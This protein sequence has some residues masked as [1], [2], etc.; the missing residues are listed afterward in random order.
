MC[1][2]YMYIFNFILLVSKPANVSL[3]TLIP[4][5]PLNNYNIDNSHSVHPI[6]PTPNE[7]YPEIHIH[8]FRQIPIT[9]GGGSK[10]LLINF[11]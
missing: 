7:N 5:R 4:I 2:T 11:S 9:G 8:V 10:I 3:M 6:H 1:L